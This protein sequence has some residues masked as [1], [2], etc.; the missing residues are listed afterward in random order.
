M[1]ADRL[2]D[3]REA[4]FGLVETLIAMAIVAMM[5]AMVFNTIA[6]NARTMTAVTERRAAALLATSAL[7]AAVGGT[8]VAEAGQSGALRW[9][10]AVEPYRPASDQAPGL[11]LVTVTVSPVAANRV[12]LRLRSLRISR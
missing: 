4:G 5:T 6:L 9:Q 3:P 1:I 7:D 2:P 10:V 8:G 11:D 12:V